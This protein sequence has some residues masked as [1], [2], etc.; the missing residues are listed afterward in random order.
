MT[1]VSTKVLV[2]TG[3]LVALLLAGVVSF[4]ASTSPDGLNR[5]AEDKGFSQTAHPGDASPFTGY[6]TKGVADKRVSKGVAGVVGSLVVLVL[7]GGVTLLVRRRT[8]E[9][10]AGDEREPVEHGGR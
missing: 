5:V 10:G 4:Y 3:L 2:V 8:P 6:G 7:A 1:K 9:T